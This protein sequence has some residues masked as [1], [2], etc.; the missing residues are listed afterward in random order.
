VDNRSHFLALDSLKP[1][2]WLTTHV[3]DMVVDG[4]KGKLWWIEEKFD[5]CFFSVMFLFN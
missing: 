1:G 2:Q 5:F 3:I 4:L